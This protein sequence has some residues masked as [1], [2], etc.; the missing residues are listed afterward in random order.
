VD[1][2]GWLRELGLDQYEAAF[3]ENGVNEEDLY[4]SRKILKI[5]IMWVRVRP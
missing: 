3:R 4:E 5:V 1:V 2:G